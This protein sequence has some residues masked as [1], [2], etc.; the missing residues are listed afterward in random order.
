MEFLRY[1]V[2]APPRQ[3]VLG[4]RGNMRM[5]NTAKA[6][7]RLIVMALEVSGFLK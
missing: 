2:P 4:R 3:M 5:A 1:M 7:L 6:I